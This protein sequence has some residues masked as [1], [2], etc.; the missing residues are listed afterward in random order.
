MASENRFSRQ[1]LLFGEEGQRS[2][3]AVSVAIVGL[4]GLGCHVNQQLAYLGVRALT[5]IDDD[6]ITGSSLNRVVGAVPQDADAGTLKVEVGR[7]VVDAIDSTVG[8]NCIPYDF[9][10]KEGFAAIQTSDFIFGC[11]DDDVA[12]IALT[13]L[14]AAFERRYFDLATDTGNNGANLWFGG[15][16][17][18]ADGELCPVCVGA[19][20][21]EAMRER[22]ATEG[23]RREDERIYGVRRG[24]LGD[25]GPAVVSLNAVVASLAVTEFMVAVTGLRD[26]QRQM[27][28]HGRRGIVT[29][30]TDPPKPDCFYCKGVWG[31]R[32]AANTERFIQGS[33][34]PSH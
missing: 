3:E 19:L 13:E 30:P 6:V 15:R 32:E 21:Q 5:L 9:R 33:P 1:E 2:L 17:I 16:I 14:C 8:P 22:T 12:R 27:E 4:G 25:H 20:D 11:I 23:E 10:T 18:L 29:I 24:A 26:P 34:D 28:Y 31:Q 7:R